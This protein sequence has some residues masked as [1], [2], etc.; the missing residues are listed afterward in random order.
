MFPSTGI[1][2]LWTSVHCPQ[3]HWIHR[4]L[5]VD[6]DESV[7]I[8]K[9]YCSAVHNTN[10]IEKSDKGVDNV[11]FTS[12]EEKG[13]Y[14]IALFLVTLVSIVTILHMFIILP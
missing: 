7:S 13:I 2:I 12:G 5:P 6:P 11:A 10:E 4:K 9:T 14:Q 8:D 1:L 3:G